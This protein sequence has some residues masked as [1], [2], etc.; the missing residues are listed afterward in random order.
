MFSLGDKVRFDKNELVGYIVRM[1]IDPLD[2][3]EVKNET[4]DI[5]YTIRVYKKFYQYG[6]ADFSRCAQD[7]TKIDEGKE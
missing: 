3:F 1:E 6:F 5:M 7:L 2:D 4:K